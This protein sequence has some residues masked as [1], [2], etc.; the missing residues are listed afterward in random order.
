MK[1]KSNR[2]KFFTI[3]SAALI[4]IV[5]GIIAVR[6]VT[7][8][9]ASALLEGLE[10]ITVERG[11]LISFIEADGVVRSEQNAILVWETSGEV[12]EVLVEAGDRVTNDQLLA[13]LDQTS[14]PSAVILAGADLVSAQQAL[15]DLFNSQM[16]QAQAQKAVEDAQQ[17]LED[18]L[19]PEM[20]QAQA[21][22]AIASAERDLERAQ[23]HY[24]I[25]MTPASA[26]SLQ[27]IYSNILLTEVAIVDLEEDVADIGKKVNQ[28]VLHPF[29][30][31]ILYKQMYSD[32]QIQ[33][34][35][36][37]DRYLGLVD[38]YEELLAPPDPV[39]VAVAEAA[40]AAA[41]AQLADALRQWERVK[42]GPTQ[43]E[44]AVLEAKLADAQREWERLKDSPTPEDIAS[45]EARLTAAQAILEMT[46]ITPPF[47]GVITDVS[48]QPGDQVNSGE[49]AFRLDDLS[50][51]LVD[52]QVSEIDINRVKVGQDVI[53][54]YDAILAMEY[55]GLVVDVSPVG[56]ETQGVVTFAV[57]VE[58][59][60]A[61][62]AVR[63]GM[64]SSANIE[65]GR[66]EN[67]LLVPNQAIR[68]LD[69]QRVVYLFGDGIRFGVLAAPQEGR[70]GGPLGGLLETFG[71][72]VPSN[73]ILPIPITVGINS[74]IYSEVIGGD[75]GEGDEILLN[76]IAELLN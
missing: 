66:V 47:D 28:T 30:S 14:L 37:Q 34:A 12:S 11:P 10:T 55:R 59:I 61:D 50:R 8:R 49:I 39:D 73:T 69:G 42:D 22:V 40:L 6:A 29:E 65:I 53:L 64:T 27:Q 72:G 45:A 13:S 71:G 16:Q 67:A 54:T 56:V 32:L 5:I 48:I 35:Q 52:L 74:D 20:T 76:P 75:L 24:G 43:A 31:R 44:I 7:Q 18:A 15:D 21:Q 4:L 62:A 33:L 63:P 68:S 60:D 26:W 3:I 9:Q 58:L 17:A 2:K 70:P 1:N 51:L 25:L 23:R 38:R 57:T 36:A 19:N 41:Q 46:S